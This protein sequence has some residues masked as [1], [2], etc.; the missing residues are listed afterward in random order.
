MTIDEEIHR[1]EKEGVLRA[2]NLPFLL[3]PAHPNGAS[4]LLVHGFTAT[5]WEVR[6]F[7]EQLAREG[8][9]TRGVR[10]PGHGTT[11]EDLAGRRWEE[12]RQTVEGAYLSHAADG[13]VYGVGVSTGALLLLA[14]A[15]SR[16]F[17]GLV[18]LSPYLSLR[19]PLARTAAL[20]RFFHPYQHHPLPA[21]LVPFYYERRPLNGIWQI[22]R[23][24]RRL[25]PA[26]PRI[27]AP[28]L[29]VSSLGDR[30]VAND[31]ARRLFSRLGSGHREYH[32][33]GP[34]VPHVLASWEN[35]HLSAT[36]DLIGAFFRHL[37]FPEEKGG[38]KGHGPALR[39][40]PGRPNCR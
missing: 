23:L 22:Q 6:P 30:T 7:G 15:E 2:E 20:L 32:L 29:V 1:A 18:L 8:F 27:T 40:S 31:S 35:P 39:S 14:L 12:W 5:P 26:L 13:P 34:E 17:A 36:Q 11:P 25:T 9:S 33:Y 19:H 16:P 24:L 10:L 38:Q 21:A 3:R 37:Q 28:A 4:V